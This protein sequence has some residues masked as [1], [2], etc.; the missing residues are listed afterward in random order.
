M[1]VKTLVQSKG[2][3]L[4]L[5]ALTT[6]L[7]LCTTAVEKRNI[8]LL[9]NSKSLCM[10]PTKDDSITVQWNAPHFGPGYKRF[11]L[12]FCTQTDATWIPIDTAIAPADSPLVV[13]PRKSI[14]SND[15]IL[16]LGVRLVDKNGMKSDIHA[17]SDSTASPAGGWLLFWPKKN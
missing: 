12:L 13:V 6:L 5:A 9:D 3:R 4:A 17:S 16:Y 7:A 10:E 1:L 15:S 8:P 2:A 14:Q 11:E